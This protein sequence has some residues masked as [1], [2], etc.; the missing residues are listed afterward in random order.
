MQGR[1]LGDHI[2]IFVRLWRRRRT[3]QSGD[4]W[5]MS[6]CSELT[7]PSPATRSC[8]SP[9]LAL[10]LPTQKQSI[11]QLTASHDDAS[12]CD[13]FVGE[14]RTEDT[15]SNGGDASSIWSRIKVL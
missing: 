1:P 14:N 3:A 12:K 11:G 4:S 7:F 5:S 2:W 6:S 10:L 8:V 15:L 13:G 9:F